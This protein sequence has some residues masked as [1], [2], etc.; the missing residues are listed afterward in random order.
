MG[1]LLSDTSGRKPNARSSSAAWFIKRVRYSNSAA[2]FWCALA[3][4]LIDE[5]PQSDSIRL[6]SMSGGSL[7]PEMLTPEA[8]L[9][10]NLEAMQGEDLD[11]AFHDALAQLE[12][13]G[14]PPPVLASVM[15]AD[16]SLIDRELPLDVVDADL[17]PFLLVWLLEWSEISEF[18][19]DNPRISGEF[20]A[21]DPSRRLSYAVGYVLENRH[22]SEG[23]FERKVTLRFHRETRPAHPGPGVEATDDATRR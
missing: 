4:E 15:S 13:I 8:S 2:K 12:M 19:W 7:T 17:L 23:L 11:R 1:R 6:Q 9:Q 18:A 16:R 20:R 3:D 10:E 5:F 22:V 14:P 21:E